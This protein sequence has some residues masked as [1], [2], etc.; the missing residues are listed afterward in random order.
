VA[1]RAA[2]QGQVAYVP[3]GNTNTNCF[4]EDDDDDDDDD[5]NNNNNNNNNNLISIYLR[6]NLTTKK[7]IIKR[8]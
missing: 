3:R 4:E 7:S 6:D 8:V 1:G 2:E 5:D